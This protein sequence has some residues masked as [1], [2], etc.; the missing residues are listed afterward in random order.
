MKK[1]LP[2]A[3]PRASAALAS[4]ADHDGAQ[5]GTRA[6]DDSAGLLDAYAATDYHVQ[7]LQVPLRPGEPHP[8]LA[9]FLAAQGASSLAILTAFNPRSQALPP[10]EN[11][12]RQ[13]ALRQRLQALGLRFLPAH[14]RSREAGE[15]PHEPLLA[16]LDAPRAVLGELIE[17]FGQNAL[18]RAEAASPTPRLMLLAAFRREL[19]EG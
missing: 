16:V 10:A 1:N 17:A 15:H 19:A 14:G 7:G 12:R 13:A 8:G 9:D 18:V 4:P 2:A 6:P 11:E 5:E 3:P